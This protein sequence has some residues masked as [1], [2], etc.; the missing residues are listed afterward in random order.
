MDGDIK[1]VMNGNA[2]RSGFLCLIALCC[3][4]IACMCNILYNSSVT[5]NKCRIG[6]FTLVCS[7]TACA[8]WVMSVLVLIGYVPNM[9]VALPR[10]IGVCF[11][12]LSLVLSLPWFSW[13][14]LK[15]YP[16]RID[17]FDNEGD[18]SGGA[19]TFGR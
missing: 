1:P 10:F 19:R 13:Y 15:D 12:F 9:G 8:C 5:K 18:R 17:R 3:A 14:L 2:L 6:W 4:G 16:D 7:V 11:W